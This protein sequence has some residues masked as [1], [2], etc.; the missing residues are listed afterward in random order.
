MK[1]FENGH[2]F[3]NNYKWETLKNQPY[4]YSRDGLLKHIVSHKITESNNKILQQILYYFEY[5]LV[6]MLRAADNLKN[7]KNYNW[8]N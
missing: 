6:Y 5:S 4:N 1:I 8:K 3:I 7:F 2:R